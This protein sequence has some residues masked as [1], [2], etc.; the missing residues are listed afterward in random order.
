MTNDMTE[1][2]LTSAEPMENEVE[3]KDSVWKKM[4][5]FGKRNLIII[6]SVLLIGGAVTLNW[7]LF[8]GTE[9]TPTSTPNTDLGNLSQT[10]STESYFAT[11]VVNRQQARDEAME[12]LQQVVDST[13]AMQEAKDQAYA[14]LVQIAAD[15]ANEANI[16]TLVCAKGFE[17][18]VA[19]IN[20]QSAN[21]IVKTTG[22]Q[23]NQIAQIQQIVYEQA[24]IAPTNVKIIEKN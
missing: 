4:L 5:Q 11:A 14:D 17:E 21:I 9:D 12:V 3:K 20:N 15:I 1:L 19:V 6:V 2:T 10:N 7:A 18:C 16:E 22:L 23:A 13:T 24:G 8:S